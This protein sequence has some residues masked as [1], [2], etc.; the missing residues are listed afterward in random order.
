[1]SKVSVP[2][3]E[4]CSACC[5]VP[6]ESRGAELD[7]VLRADAVVVE[8]P[9]VSSS[10]LNRCPDGPAVVMSTCIWRLTGLVVTTARAVS[11]VASYEASAHCIRL[12][13]VILVGSSVA[14]GASVVP[15][16]SEGPTLLKSVV[17]EPGD[18]SEPASSS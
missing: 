18:L 9:A 16:R 3:R 14:L 1:M 6:K 13:V 10:R 11:V 17:E 4:R 12:G 2:V 8:R 15:E 7:S 5:G